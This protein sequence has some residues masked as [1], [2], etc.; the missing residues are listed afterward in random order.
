MQHRDTAGPCDTRG[1]REPFLIREMLH[2]LIHLCGS[3]LGSLK[4]FPVLLE[5][6]GPELDTI[7]QL[8]SYQGRVQREENL[9]RPSVPRAQR[10]LGV[11]LLSHP[12]LRSPGRSAPNL[13]WYLGLSSPRSNTP[14][15]PS[16][17]PLNF[18]P[19]NSPSRPRL[20]GRQHSHKPEDTAPSGNR[21]AGPYRHAAGLQGTSA[22]IPRRPAA[23]ALRAA[24]PPPPPARPAR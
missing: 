3:A 11:T 24:R 23:V 13:C 16:S 10:W 2:S 1:T 12:Q 14:H 19:P 15:R 8:C 7:F 17:V 9:S 18:S 4:K 5:L 22:G 20:V 21:T 6:R